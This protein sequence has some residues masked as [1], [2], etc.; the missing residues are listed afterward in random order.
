MGRK[1]I[2]ITKCFD[3]KYRKVTNTLPLNLSKYLSK[4][5]TREKLGCS[6]RLLRCQF[7]VTIKSYYC[8]QILMVESFAFSAMIRFKCFDISKTLTNKT[9]KILPKKMY[10]FI[11]SPSV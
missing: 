3:K 1:K 9:L 4:H 10:S 8:S 5:L 2:E 7:Y 11:S 6:K